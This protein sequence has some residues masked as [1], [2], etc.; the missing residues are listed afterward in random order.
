MQAHAKKYAYHGGDS[1]V[2]RINPHEFAGDGELLC[3]TLS[4]NVARRYGPVITRFA[5][6]DVPTKTM[7]IAEWLNDVESLKCLRKEGYF[8]V[9]V[10]GE[11]DRFDFPVDMVV[12]LDV[13]AVTFDRVLSADEMLALRDDFSDMHGPDG[14]AAVGWDLWLEDLGENIDDALENL[15]WAVTTDGPCH[16]TVPADDMWREYRVAVCEGLPPR[17]YLP[18]VPTS[19]W[20]IANNWGCDDAT[21]PT[22]AEALRIADQWRREEI[23]RRVEYLEDLKNPVISVEEDDCIPF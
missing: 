18:G 17:Y 23:A 11:K 14:P 6:N 4:V 15:G 10:T 16:V 7:S 21:A 8:A 22:R 9:V 2:S 13:A 19:Y 3:T 5:V 1:A 12:V 20:T